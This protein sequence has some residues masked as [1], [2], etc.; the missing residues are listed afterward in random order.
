MA[1]NDKTAGRDKII[2]ALRAELLGPAPA[3][4]PL[5]RFTFEKKEESYGP[6]T[7]AATGEEILERDPLIRYGVGVL[8]PVI[9]ATSSK[10]ADQAIVPGLTAEDTEG[11]QTGAWEGS[12]GR[13]GATSDDA[14]F[15][16][17]GANERF[18]HDYGH[19]VPPGPRAADRPDDRGDRRPIR[20]DQDRPPGR[21]PA[22]MVDPRPGQGRVA[23][24]L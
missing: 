23:A 11:P 8:Y 1:E 21:R 18:Y 2:E 13:L 9:G 22:Y 10:I 3:Y 14:D 17:S 4:K 6:W 5:D 20:T 7:N 15:D 12:S 19:L 16:L 24:D